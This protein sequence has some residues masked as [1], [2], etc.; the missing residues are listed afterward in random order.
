MESYFADRLQRELPRIQSGWDRQ[1]QALRTQLQQTQEQID[2]LRREA[3]NARAEGLAPEDQAKLQAR[4]DSE[5]AAEAL[6]KKESATNDLFFNTYAFS[7]LTRFDKF[8]VTE[9]ELLACETTDAMDVL[10]AQK[11]AEYYRLLAEGKTPDA[12]RAANAP[13]DKANAPAGRRAP[14]GSTKGSDLGGGG[15]PATKSSLLTEQGIDAMS[16]NIKSL[17]S[18]PG[19]GIG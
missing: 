10:A 15:S 14:A 9:E 11:Q 4:W 17:F 8:G 5:D 1:N 7:V 2:S 12:A 3:R 16:K 19:R 18:E 6:R 13:T